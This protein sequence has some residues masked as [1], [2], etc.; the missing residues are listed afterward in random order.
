MHLHGKRRV[1]DEERA[2]KQ[3]LV[4]DDPSYARGWQRRRLD[5]EKKRRRRRRRR[6]RGYQR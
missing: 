6:R 1:A 5:M 4:L 3:V 2:K